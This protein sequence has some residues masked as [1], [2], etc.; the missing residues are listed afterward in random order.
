MPPTRLLPVRASST[1]RSRASSLARDPTASPT[2]WPTASPSSA[3]RDGHF[4][5]SQEAA[6]SRRRVVH[7][8][9]D[10]TGAAIMQ[11]LIARVRATPSIRV[12]EGYVADELIV[13]D[14]RVAGVRLVRPSA[15]DTGSYEFFPACAVVLAT[16]GIGAL[17][18]VTTNP[19]YARG[20][21]I[22]MA[23]RVG[24]VVAD[25][26]F[27][28][29]HPT[30][31]DVGADPAPLAT[32][33][34]RG[35]GAT[36]VNR[37]GERFML[38]SDPR[39]EL[40]PRDIVAR[41]VF[42]EI[43]AG[44]GA[45]LDCRAA[46]G[47]HFAEAFP[48]VYAHCRAAGID[49]VTELIPVAPAAHYHMGGIA[50]DARARTSVAG[51]WAI[52]EVAS[53]GLHGANR[54]ASNS[55]LEAIVFGARAAADIGGLDQDARRAPLVEIRRVGQGAPHLGRR[56][57]RDGR[58]AAPHH[59]ATRWRRAHRVRPAPGPR[60]AARHRAQ[61]RPRQRAGQHG[62]RRALRLRKRALARGKPR[63]A[64][65]QRLSRSQSG[66]CRAR[67][68]HACR[69]RPHH[70]RVRAGQGC[71]AAAGRGLPMSEHTADLRLPPLL[72][73]RAVADALAED[74]GPTG[75]ITTQATVPQDARAYG[76]IAARKPGVVAGMQLVKAAFQALDPAAAVEVI[77]TDGGR[78]AAGGEIA[79]V[80]GNAR[81]LLGAERVAM[82]FLGHLSGIAT[83]TQRYV[84]AVAGTHARIIDTRKTT[85]GYCAPSRS[86]PCAAGGGL[87]H[88]FGLF[89][90]ILI[91]DNHIVAAGGVGP[92]LE[93]ARAQAGHTVKIEVEVTTLDEL[94][95]ALAHN[96]DAVLLDNMPP[97]ML[98]TAVAEVAGRAVTEASGGVTLETV[99]GIA[100]T[101]VDLISV[102]ALT[103]SAPNLDVGFDFKTSS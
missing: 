44:R 92:A 54:L 87:N 35:E 45:F 60:H 7:V 47:A 10:R 19:A 66:A 8:S 77:V 67:L 23:A 13:A 26:E 102:G 80:S 49:P 78:V 82:N 68:P 93:R 28:Q 22:A 97:P 57:R 86:S 11:A 34:L 30:A 5:L 101:G 81:A 43:A 74:L 21:L 18:S 15:V 3:T 29:F 27:V 99:R 62:S 17:Y 83:L 89:D 46:I 91:K 40:A 61:R 70:G 4:Q 31:L 2:F 100:E 64:C 84:E 14:G 88:R 72:V 48:T 1:R 90:A 24:A 103:H 59:G 95:Q 32:E 56:P 69:P 38:R 65:P 53:T 9:G 96:P 37:Q 51:L 6:H 33:A 73:E 98:R 79:R 41:G 16:G 20:E 55:L 42:Q 75:D 12:L 94:T 36:L 50:T 39:G 58:P 71:R 52:G 85:P 25:A 63:R 76:I